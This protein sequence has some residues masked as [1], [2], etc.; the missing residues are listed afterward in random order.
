MQKLDRLGWAAGTQFLSHGVRVGI[1]ADSEESLA[2]VRECYPPEWKPTEN[3][4]VDLLFS[5][6]FG[7]TGKHG[8]TRFFNLV[9]EGAARLA[10]T[11]DREEALQALEQ[12]LTLSVAELAPRRLFVH[13]GV[14]SWKG[15]AIVIPGR[16]YT[17]K[18]TLT[19][20]LVRA[21]ARYYSDEYAVLDRHGRVHP[22]PRKLSLRQPEGP[23]RRCD[24]AEL[25]GRSG[26]TPIPVGLVVVTQFREGARWKARTLSPGQA[27]LEL[28][29]NTVP[30]RRRPEFALTTLRTALEG[31][32]TVKSARGDA[33]ALARVLLRLAEAPPVAG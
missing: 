21:G 28:L 7:G 10:R 3:P 4:V 6:R 16:S 22:Y 11:L 17:G 14:V 9:Y 25:G 1:R 27:A 5:V 32:R 31:A 8:G 26:S 24:A 19:A 13:A 18:S 29:A 23:P 33:D 20:A 2:L 15:K 12:Y 30:A